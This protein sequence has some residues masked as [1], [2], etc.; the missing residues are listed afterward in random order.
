ML[1]MV[2]ARRNCSADREERQDLFSGLL[3]AAEDG[4]VLNDEELLGGLLR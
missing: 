4:E 3:E 2:E 1:E